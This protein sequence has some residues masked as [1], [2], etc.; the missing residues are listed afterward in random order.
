MGFLLGNKKSY[1][2]ALEWFKNNL[3]TGKGII[4]HTR[5]QEPCPEVTG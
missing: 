5:L 3:V 4:V 2:K 1:E